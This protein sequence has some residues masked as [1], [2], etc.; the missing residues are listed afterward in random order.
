MAVGSPVLQRTVQYT[1]ELVDNTA[2]V[3]TRGTAATN[4]F[5]ESLDRTTDK[6]N[7]QDVSYIKVVASVGAFRHG[8]RSLAMGL[9]NLGIINKET[10][11]SFY[12]LVYAVDVFT[13]VFL[14][15]KGIIGIV[16]LLRNE[17]LKLALVKTYHKILDNPSYAAVA[18]GASIAA[19][20]I[21]GYLVGRYSGGSAVRSPQGTNASITQNINFYGGG[22][23]EQR[24]TS[25]GALEGAGGL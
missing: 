11:K 18:V 25:R 5:G 12:N 6:L 9:E 10:N 8:L 3:A 22:N 7:R 24:Y 4:R 20:G 23:A 15:V 1:F 17:E 19:A 16:T 21:T 14:A 2:D 13:G